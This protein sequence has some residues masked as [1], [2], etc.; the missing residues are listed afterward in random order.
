MVVSFKKRE[1]RIHR[2]LFVRVNRRNEWQYQIVNE[3]SNQFQIEKLK[4]F[5]VSSGE[6]VFLFRVQ[7]CRREHGET[8]RFFV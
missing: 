8:V 6:F 1:G 4:L 2:L 5:T 7:A 3:S